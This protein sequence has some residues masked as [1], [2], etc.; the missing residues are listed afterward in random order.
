MAAN[1]PFSQLTGALKVY[2]A[3]YGETI[4]DVDALPGGNWVEFGATDG[5][6]SFKHSGKVTFFKDNDHQGNVTGVRSEEDPTVKLKVVDLTLEN[7]AKI[8]SGTS[9]LVNGTTT[10]GSATRKLPVKRGAAL[11]EYAMLLKGDTISPYGLYP[12]MFVIP[13]LVFS[14]EPEIKFGKNLRGSL[15]VEG[16]V[17]EDDAQAEDDKLGWLIVRTS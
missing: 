7:W 4:P 3:L 12:G 1:T 14:S 13:R 9:K 10:L 2:L 16:H 15:D 8:I 17:M 11:V 5:D 6:Q